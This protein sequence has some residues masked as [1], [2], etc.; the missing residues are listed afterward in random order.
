MAHPPPAKVLLLSQLH[1]SLLSIPFPTSD[2]QPSPSSFTLGHRT[3]PL[4]SGRAPSLTDLLLQVFFLQF[5]Q[6]TSPKSPCFIKVLGPQSACLVVG[7]YQLRAPPPPSAHMTSTGRE[8]GW[9]PREGHTQL[10]PRIVPEPSTVTRGPNPLNRRSP[11]ETSQCLEGWRADHA[12]TALT[13]PS[14]I[15]FC[16]QHGGGGFVVTPGYSRHDILIIHR[17][18]PISSS[19]KPLCFFLHPYHKLAFRPAQEMMSSDYYFSWHAMAGPHNKY[20]QCH[21]PHPGRPLSW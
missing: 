10:Y 4:P 3:R 1:P 8:G 7:S 17:T 18:P 15:H 21:T 16:L 13:S 11:T 19:I 5:L 14:P 12:I 9:G 6:N 20:P 2:C